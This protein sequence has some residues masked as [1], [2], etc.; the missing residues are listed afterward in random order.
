[1]KQ[2]DE[3][4]TALDALRVVHG[5]VAFGRAIQLIHRRKLHLHSRAPR[6]KFP[7]SKYKKLYQIQRGMCPYCSCAM[8]L[9]KGE[10]EIDH[11]DPNRTDFNA[12]NNL[13]L[14]HKRCNRKKSSRAIDAEAKSHNRTYI[15]LLT[16]K[17]LA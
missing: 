2:N 16:G 10:V 6:Q 12:E 14:L 15:H 3:L 17:N 7:W 11:R 13:Q 9:Q 8:F 5:D 4:T 1:M